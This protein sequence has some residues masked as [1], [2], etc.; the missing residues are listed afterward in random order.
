MRISINW[1]LSLIFF[2]AKLAVLKVYMRLHIL[3]LIFDTRNQLTKLYNIIKKDLKLI[4]S[5]F[6]EWF[7]FGENF[8]FSQNSKDFKVITSMFPQTSLLWE[9]FDWEWHN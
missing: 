7:V 3:V 5:K 2:L 1:K 8:E 4:Y 9:C 6:F